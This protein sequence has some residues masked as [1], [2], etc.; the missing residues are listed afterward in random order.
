MG[1]TM[2]F[3]KY[4]FYLFCFLI[5]F[6]NTALATIGGV[7][8]APG[9]FLLLPF[10]CVIAT[11]QI[12]KIN[13][14]EKRLLIILSLFLMFSLLMSFYF[15]NDYSPSFVLDRGVR[16]FLLIMP[17][18]MVFTICLR[19][20][21]ETLKKGVLIIVSIAIFSLL[22][23]L[24]FSGVVNSKSLIQYSTALS[25]HRLRGF[26]LEASTFGFQIVTSLLLLAIVKKLPRASYIPLLF[27]IT[28]ASTSKGALICF[29]LSVLLYI[30]F[31]LH[32]SLKLLIGFLV[33]FVF[34]LIFNDYIF[35]LFENDIENYG[36]V[37]TRGTMLFTSFIILF[38]YPLG[39]GF[40][41]YLPAIY[42]NGLQG[43]ELF[44]HVYPEYLNFSE[45]L[46]YFHS[47]EVKGVST[48]TFFFDWAIFAGWPFVF[49][50]IY[51]NASL[52]R[53]FVKKNA[54]ADATLLIF[55][56]ISICTYVPID[57]RYIVPFAYTFLLYRKRQLK[58]YDISS[59]NK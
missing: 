30:Y 21:Y 43:I 54:S 15:L 59:I 8:T 55:I 29:V 35:P 49:A 52:I 47:G 5:P 14:L 22:L 39:V 13:I 50:F 37:A 28:T 6:E 51:F 56:V 45:V 2:K 36:T 42:N 53:F 25:P 1:V 32:Y 10:F 46:T 40:F 24:S 20:D 18:M 44:Q 57:G 33:P 48:K 3:Q 16:F 9:G 12:N 19:Q 34:M 11:F 58:R 31:R 4:L 26:T 17:S 7:F 27:I 23:S 38:K 41:G